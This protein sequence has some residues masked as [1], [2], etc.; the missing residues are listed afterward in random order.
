MAIAPVS[1]A[2]DDRPID[3]IMA[4][5]QRFMRVEASAGI[6]LI[7]CTVIALVWA[8]SPWRDSYHDIWHTYASVGFGDW[9]LKMSLAHFVNDGLMAIFFFVVG[10]EIKRELLVG[11]LASL[12]KASIPIAGALG[13]MIGPALVFILAV[14]ML[15]GEGVDKGWAIPMATDIAFVVGIMAILGPRVPLGLKVFV[16]ALAI[17]DDIGA[18]L[19]IAIFYTDT[20]SLPAIIVAIGLLVL[21]ATM[22]KLHVRSPLVY[23]L[24]GFAMWLM[25]LRSG[26]HATIGGVLLALTIPSRV[27]IDGAHFVG[28]ARKAVDEF[29][30]AGGNVDDIMTNPRR[31]S[32]VQ[33]LEE[34]CEH[35]QTPLGRLEF[36]LHTWVA[37][38]IVPIFALANAGVSFGSVGS[39]AVSGGLGPGVA[40]GLVIGKPIGITIGTLIAVKIGLGIL[41]AGTRWS[42]IVGAGFLA[43]IG[44]T[45]SLFIANLGFKGDDETTLLMIAKIGILAGSLVSVLIG[46]AILWFTASRAPDSVEPASA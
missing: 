12:K 26:V 13:G 24:I 30:A 5:F 3:V 21:S 33:G 18:V 20:V 6:L 15:G 34:A 39:D 38:L 31:Q 25:L 41:P 11:E 32:V 46:F 35:V 37:F 2:A 45:M 7:I 8:N 27:R 9:K 10:L 1:P 22:N 16:T 42:Q 17:V 19:V 28:F 40:L 4:P 36:G 43:G 14:T 29:E 44:F 23:G